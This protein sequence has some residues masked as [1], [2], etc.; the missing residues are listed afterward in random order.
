M[1]GWMDGW[2]DVCRACMGMY[3]YVYICVHMY[4]YAVC[5]DMHVCVWMYTYVYGC[6]CMTRPRQMRCVICDLH[7]SMPLVPHAVIGSKKAVKVRNSK[8]NVDIGEYE[9]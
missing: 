6:L 7:I 8:V 5:M 4:V 2:M 3:A 1:D 9:Q